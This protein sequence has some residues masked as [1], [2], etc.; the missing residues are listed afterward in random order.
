MNRDN[1]AAF[2]RIFNNLQY[3][4]NYC[5]PRGEKII[6]LEDYGFQLKPY[7][8][9]SNFEGRKLSLDYIKAEFIWY[10]TG[11]KYNVSIGEFAKMWKTLVNTDGSINS[12]YG[13]YIFGQQNQ[14]GRVADLLKKD[15]DSRRGS[16]I[17]LSAEHLAS[18]TRD[19]PCTYSINFRIRNNT[20]NMSVSMRSQDAIFGLGADIPCFSFVHE[21]MYL[22]L[23]ETHTELEY[24]EYHHRADSFH[25]YEKHFG[26]LQE[27]ADSADY[28]EVVCPHIKDAGEVRFL[29]ALDYS[30]IP[31]EYKF[32]KWLTSF[33][34]CIKY[35]NAVQRIIEATPTQLTLDLHG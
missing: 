33:D 17:I 19:Y 4:G 9:F 20:L 21:M 14:F 35:D 24:G 34:D 11:D 7:N 29:L 23:K 25:V 2:R 15:K 22:I 12:N 30:V 3:F 27:M 16:I 10:M 18:D 28:T 32:T 26:M 6:E 1:E 8:R 5:S 13:Q 31:E